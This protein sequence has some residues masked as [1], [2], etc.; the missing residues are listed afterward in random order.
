MVKL[1][2]PR[3][4]IVGES[5]IFLIELA[6]NVAT[7]VVFIQEFASVTTHWYCAKCGFS[8]LPIFLIFNWDVVPVF[9]ISEFVVATTVR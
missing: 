1:V 7:F 8:L 4:Q 3:S 9:L 2:V 6:D 5:A